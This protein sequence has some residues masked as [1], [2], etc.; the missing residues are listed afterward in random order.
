MA[1]DASG[2]TLVGTILGTLLFGPSFSISESVLGRY[3]NE[4]TVCVNR[5]LFSDVSLLSIHYPAKLE[6]AFVLAQ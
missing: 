2:F 4:R 5:R 6:L 1:I 3:H